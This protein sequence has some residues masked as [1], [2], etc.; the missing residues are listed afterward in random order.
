MS[1][2]ASTPSTDS[3]PYGGPSAPSAGS[4]EP[5]AGPHTGLQA[6]SRVRTRHLQEAKAAGERFSM[7]TSY[8]AM[9][10]GIFDEAGID[11]LLVGDSAGSTVFGQ[12]TTLSVTLEQMIMLTAAVSSAARRA[13]VVADVPFG[14][15]EESPQQAVRTCVRLLKEG[16]AHAVK[17]EGGPE[18]AEHIRA[19]VR[20][21]IPVMGHVGFTP[22]SEHALGGYRIQGRGEQAQQVIDDARAIEAVGAFAVLLEM[23]PA[24]VG[25]RTDAALNVPTVGIGAGA[26]TTGQVLVWQDALGLNGGRVAR[27]VRQYA[28]LRSVMAE[29]VGRYAQE[30]RDGSFPAPEHTY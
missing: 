22:Q 3:S 11:V 15:Y 9:T 21:G 20:A 26:D 1:D 5:Q 30:V 23:V 7:L 18:L 16:G 12:A 24:E 19:V 28:D 29:A 27:F 2:A 10:A 6:V 25:A 8:D 13:L 17:I 4:P 14:T